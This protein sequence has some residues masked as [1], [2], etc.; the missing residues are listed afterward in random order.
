MRPQRTSWL[1]RCVFLTGACAAIALVT[2]VDRHWRPNWP[3]ETLKRTVPSVEERADR[4]I[5]RFVAV[6]RTRFPG[7]VVGL[8]GAPE[9]LLIPGGACGVGTALAVL[10]DQPLGVVEGDEGADGIPHLLDGPEDASVHDLLLEGAEETLD[11]AIIR[12]VGGGASMSCRSPP[13]LGY[14]ETIR[15]M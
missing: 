15:D 11:H 3:D 5:R 4:W 7:Q 13:G 1:R 8:R 6:Y 2:V 14:G 9:G 12:H 10:L